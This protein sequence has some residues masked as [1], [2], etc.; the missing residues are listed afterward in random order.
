[1]SRI[2]PLSSALET[3]LVLPLAWTRSIL[4]VADPLG[5]QEA[6][7]VEEVAVGVPSHRDGVHLDDFVPEPVGIRRDALPQ[8]VERVERRSVTARRS[9]R[10]GRRA[11]GRCGSGPRDGFPVMKA[12]SSGSRR[13]R[14]MPSH[15][16]AISDARSVPP[17]PR[18][19]RESNIALTSSASV[20]GMRPTLSR[21]KSVFASTSSGAS[22]QIT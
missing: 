2:S 1:M 15:W 18:R 12:Q 3:D 8:R 14:S 20:S 16:A 9:F 4:N 6:D 13:S 5:D 10:R 22:Y 17:A 7:L 19:P 21:L 11:E